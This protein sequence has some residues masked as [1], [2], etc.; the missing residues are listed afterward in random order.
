M[1]ASSMVCTPLFLKAD[2]HRVTTICE[3][4]LRARR[5]ALISS[6]VNVSP[7]KYLSMRT[8][9]ASA[10]ASTMRSRHFWH[11]ANNS[12]GISRSSNFV[13]WVESSQKMAFIFKR[14][15]TP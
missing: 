3:A 15:T 14:S 9:L 13:P 12:A 2:P 11:S 8:S 4:R 7:P 6:G 1:T 5:P 10:A